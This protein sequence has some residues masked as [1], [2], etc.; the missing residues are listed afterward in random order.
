[1][2]KEDEIR[3]IYVSRVSEY[4]AKLEKDRKVI[5]LLSLLRLFLFVFGIMATVLMFRINNVAGFTSLAGLIVLFA[6]I[7]KLFSDRSWRRDFN[8][9]MIRING[10]ALKSVN[11]DYSGFEGGA[12]YIDSSHAFS[13]DLDIFGKDSF[14]QSLN[15]TCTEQGRDVLA[16]W[17]KDPLPLCRDIGRR[18]EV[19]NELASEMEWRHKFAALGLMNITS[20][21]E[22]EQ[23]FSWLNE[24]ALFSNKSF[25]KLMLVFLPVASSL[26][27]ALSISGT[28]NYSFF[29]GLFLLNLLFIAI[30]LGKIN[31][32]HAKVSKRYSY[33]AVVSSLIGHFENY[34]FKSAYLAE[35]KD[36]LGKDKVSAMGNI[37]KLAR[38]IH[39]FDSRLNMIMG[40]ILNGLFL[41]DY[42]CVTRIEAWKSRLS[43]KVP[44][45]FNA[46]AEADAFS[47][48]ADY[49]F[50][51]PG[52][53]SP[54]LSNDGT[55]LLAENLG[56]HLI[57][58]RKRIVNDY[59]INKQACIN[60]ITGANMA[61][62]STFLRTVGTNLVMAMCGAPV[63]ATRFE[64]TPADLFTSMRT[65]D[66][67]S[68]DESYFFAELKRLRILME[69]IEEGHNV[70]FILDEILKGTNSKDKS[71][72]SMA[73]LRKVISKGGTG[74][75][76]T[77]DISLG[78]LLNEYP[79]NIVNSC[80]EIEI[81]GGEVI[82]DYLL[83]EGITTKMNA[84]ILMQQQ[85]II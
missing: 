63:C 75:V 10:E 37:K 45:W 61:G 17:L 40:V 3:K 67:L 41:W 76:A 22:T 28:I 21:S 27:L 13:H 35:L 82:F 54:E 60:V 12:A 73:F 34:D 85:G 50:N 81:S 14:F 4:K 36:R 25:L 48:L 30:N 15:R 47:S 2:L 51:K 23:F 1:M 49:T 66:S 64:F 6:F 55:F 43:D 32:V 79:E 78:S 80:F 44:Q 9:N 24:K 52:Y 69:R 62:K 5:L 65:S 11:E 39:S 18:K 42:Q 20:G 71:E 7:L 68:E 46:L 74:M 72:G 38:L 57:N 19:I 26:L 56:H 83:R 84:R 70:F 33:L 53:V 59:L 58:S 8:S 29:I 77:H 16:G 31:S